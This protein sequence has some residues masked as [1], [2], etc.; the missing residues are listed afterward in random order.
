M[1]SF[2]RRLAFV[3]MLTSAVALIVVFII[4]RRVVNSDSRFETRER[5]RAEALILSEAVAMPLGKTGTGPW[6]DE[7]V[8]RSGRLTDTRLTVISIDGTVFGD[9]TVSGEA[10]RN[11][12][13][14]A[15]RPEVR[16]ALAR[17]EGTNERF[18]NTARE[19]Q[20]YFAVPIRYEGRVLGVARASLS[21]ARIE[22]RVSELRTS[23]G[24]AL[25]LVL[26]LA[27]GLA[28]LL[29]RPMAAPMGRILEGAQA[30]ARGDLAQRIAM[31]EET[32]DEFGE[33]ARVLN[34]AAFGLQEQLA[35]TARERARFSAVLSAMED[36]LLAV[37]HRGVVLLVNEALSRSHTLSGST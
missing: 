9:T 27:S 26:A 31:N 8:D 5:L 37:D 1:T 16:D 4:Q 22:T 7:L 17:G 11:L 6:L 34:Q 3:G 18:S 21:L 23:L 28:W 32:R 13:N 2:R 14:H 29:S 25:L 20:M 36:G 30:L 15:G 12:D 10:L 24:L 33:L 35:A 19:P